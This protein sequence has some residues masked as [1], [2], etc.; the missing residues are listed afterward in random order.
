MNKLALFLLL[1]IISKSLLAQTD[2]IPYATVY[3]YRESELQGPLKDLGLILNSKT[4]H[5]YTFGKIEQN[6]KMYFK[7]YKWKSNKTKY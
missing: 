6:S 5:N 1:F 7:I 3:I 2:T 4:I